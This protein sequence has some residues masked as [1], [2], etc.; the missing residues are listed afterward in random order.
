[1][2][3]I[4]IKE[5][6]PTLNKFWAGVHWR[7]RKEIADTWHL[8][9]KNA[10]RKANLPKPL[11]KKDVPYII[12]CTQFCKSRVRDDDNAIVGTKL[13]KDALTHWGYIE[14][15]DY[16]TFNDGVTSTRKGKENMMVILIM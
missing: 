12:Q 9:F 14:D 7:K 10:F 8:I 6:P 3:R 16:K 5:L 4:E 13:C 1:M 11:P 2:Y 15:D